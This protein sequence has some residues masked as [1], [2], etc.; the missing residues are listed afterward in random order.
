ME[1]VDSLTG[2]SDVLL[3][4]K[5]VTH[6]LLVEYLAPFRGLRYIGINFIDNDK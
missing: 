6:N 4:L 2:G 1:V 3:V 5:F